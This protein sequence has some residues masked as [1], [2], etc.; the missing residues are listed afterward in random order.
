MK[1]E[2]IKE[3]FSEYVDGELSAADAA[4]VEQHLA[5]CE[6]CRAEFEALRQTAALVRSLPRADAPQGLARSVTESVGKQMAVRKRAAI[7]RW[8]GVGGW[9]AAAAAL[10]IVIQLVPWEGPLDPG[11]LTEPKIAAPAADD[12]EA[13]K[14][15]VLPIPDGRDR[16]LEIASKKKAAEK[17]TAP[18][19]PGRRF[20]GKNGISRKKGAGA[21]G[22]TREAG[23]RAKAGKTAAGAERDAGR[24]AEEAAGP[25]LAAAKKDRRA[26]GA[27]RPVTLAAFAYECADLKA[28]RAAVLKA[29]KAVRGKT[30]QPAKEL[31]AANVV[32]AVVPRNEVIGLIAKLKL[33]AWPPKP[34]AP[35]KRAGAAPKAAHYAPG[36]QR[37]IKRA[38]DNGAQTFG[39]A[40]ADE[41]AQAR[42]RELAR[43]KQAA[44]AQTQQALKEAPSKA[45][46]AALDKA[47]A[48]P[49]TITINIILEVKAKR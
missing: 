46:E 3:L 8:T 38:A 7:L 37:S 26:R 17:D 39:T 12:E 48:A 29:L 2:E 10:I 47:Q 31:R 49:P 34:K 20:A 11:V 18:A 21:L 35:G 27:E 24:E 14:K 41:A 30:I 43:A 36:T 44:Q 13:G 40:Q 16:R 28:G 5:G 6:A 23:R 33:S 45:G 42:A 4:S 32:T 1:C 22:A 15:D 9:L 25:K 19:E